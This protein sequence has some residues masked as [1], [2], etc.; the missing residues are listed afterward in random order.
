[1]GAILENESQPKEPIMSRHENV[2]QVLSEL[3]QRIISV[4]SGQSQLSETDTRQ[5]LINPLFRA[6][7]WDFGDFDSVKSEVRHK[8]F[9]EPVDYAFYSSQNK[10]CPI[11]LLEAK[12]FGTDLSSK[13]IIK[14]ICAYMNEFGIQ[15]GVISD[16]NKYILYNSRGGDSFDHKKFLTLEIKTAGTEDGIPVPEL[17]RK[18]IGLLSRDCLENQEIQ[19]AYE[20]HIRNQQIQRAM[21]SLL[22]VPF[23]TLVTSIRR[24]FKEERV[25]ANPGLRITKQHIEEFLTSIA[26]EEGKIAVDLEAE[27]V[28]SDGEMIGTAAGTDNVEQPKP[29]RSYSKRI[30]I[31]DLLD[32]GLIHEGDNWRFVTKGE[33]TW[34]RVV[35]TGEL[36]VKGQR[37]SNPSKAGQSLAKGGVNGW[38]GW[39]YKDVENEWRRISQLRQ[40]YRE[41]REKA[42]LGAVQ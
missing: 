32:A 27:E 36:E 19:R 11:L 17:A 23:E 7:G 8:A 37:Y 38:Y 29:V 18:M 16:G 34:G 3:Q 9:N 33:V 5:G 41:G 42:E 20:D 35:G 24:E 31:K 14:Q 40:V 39:H 13:K 15:W 28:H 10:S 2:V 12:R 26:D 30:L 1:M 25:R 21:S 4:E 6:L 22:S